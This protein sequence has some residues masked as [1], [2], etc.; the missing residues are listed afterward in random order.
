M[1]NLERKIIWIRYFAQKP[2]NGFTDCLYFR[3]GPR[4]SLGSLRVFVT[5]TGWCGLVWLLTGSEGSTSLFCLQLF[6]HCRVSFHQGT[7]PSDKRRASQTIFVCLLFSLPK[8]SSDLYFHMH[9]VKLISFCPRNLK[10]KKTTVWIG[11]DGFSAN[12]AFSFNF[13]HH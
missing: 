13:P 3:R 12:M 4:N 8:S 7:K 2:G 5:Q 1:K 11:N 10:K 9:D 6:F